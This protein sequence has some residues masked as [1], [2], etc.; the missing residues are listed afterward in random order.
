ME[1]F[2][3]SVESS[4]FRAEVAG[5]G[6]NGGTKLLQEVEESDS[7]STMAMLS[8]TNL[9]SSKEG[10]RVFKT[11]STIEKN[12][13]IVSVTEENECIRRLKARLRQIEEN[14]EL[15]KMCKTVCLT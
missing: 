2:E 5:M 10:K 1:D 4:F 15:A 9:T 6:E 14:V 8:A 7:L 12:N 13:S 3:P 11:F